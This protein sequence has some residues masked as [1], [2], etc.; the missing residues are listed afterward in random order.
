VGFGGAVGAG[1]IDFLVGGQAHEVRVGAQMFGRHV[2]VDHRRADVG[3][4][5]DLLN[6]NEA[7]AV[8]DQV[9]FP[10]T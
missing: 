8:D 2:G 1:W 3:V 6:R 9:K 5:E 7:R 4:A 10:R